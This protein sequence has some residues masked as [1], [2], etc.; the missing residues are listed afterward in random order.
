MQKILS[1]VLSTVHGVECIVKEVIEVMTAT[2]VYLEEIEACGTAVPK[3]IAKIVKNCQKI[4]SICEDIL[5]LNSTLC[6]NDDDSKVTAPACFWELLKAT[7]ELAYKI[8]STLRLIAKLPG[9]TETCFVDATDKVENSYNN[10]L[11]NIELCID[12]M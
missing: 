10:F 7:T 8:D 6:A 1:K 11:P 9:D 3:E 5:H 4:I 2:I 12:E